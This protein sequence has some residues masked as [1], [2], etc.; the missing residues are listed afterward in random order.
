[1]TT[2]SYL[3]GQFTAGFGE[4]AGDR[5]DIM[6]CG[7]MM[8]QG[9]E[10]VTRERTLD[11]SAGVTA[12]VPSS[13]QF[14]SDVR[15]TGT[16]SQGE[17]FDTFSFSVVAGQTYS[18]ALRGA[19][20]G[21]NSLADPLLFVF[22]TTGAV[23]EFDDDGGV[24][25]TS[26]LTFTAVATGTYTLTSEP[27]DEGDVGDYTVD[28][29]QQRATDRVPATFEGAVTIG[30]GTTFGHV[31]TGGDVDRYK[32]FLEAGKLY[33]FQMAGGTDANDTKAAVTPGELDT[34]L[35]IYRPDGTFIGRSD[36]LGASDLSSGF[37]YTAPTTGFY[38]LDASAAGA[39]QTGG[40]TLDVTAIDP[41]Q[42]DPLDSI[43]WRN[44]TTIPTTTVNGR[45]TAYVYFG[46][47]DENFG[48]TADDGTS[49]MVTIDW[50]PF[51]KQQVM[52]ALDEFER[53]LG[54]DYQVTEDSSQATFRLLKTV[55]T[56]YGA[57][58]FPQDPVFGGDQGVGV[59]NVASG[60]W[61]FQQQQSLERGGFSYAVILHE[62]GHAHGLAHPHDRGGGSEI[63]LGVAGSSGP[64][65]Y[66]LFDLNQGVYSVMSY[67]DANPRGANGPSPFTGATID[68]GWSG[69]LGAFDI[70]VLQ[71]K[72]GVVDRETGNNVYELR[73]ANARGTFYSTIWD[74]AG[75]DEI[76]Y[77]GAR[78]SQIDL[79][80]ATLDYTATGGGVVSFV[81]GI[82]GG[83]TIANDVV[84]EN[85]T[86]G[87]G[88][89]VL[90]G[91]AAGNVLTGNA[92]DDVLHGRVGA[93]T[94][95]GGDGADVLVGGAGDDRLQGGFGVDRFV[96]EA[97]GGIDTIVDFRRGDKIDLTAFVGVD[98][99][100]VTLSNGRI[101][102]ENGANDITI[103][104]QGDRVSDSAFLF[105]T[106][107]S[108]TST[109]TGDTV[110]GSFSGSPSG[111]LVGQF[112]D[113]ILF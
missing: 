5:I 61:R 24:S 79:T 101:F 53:I 108:P 95:I 96:F 68:R 85:A 37:S 75:T 89:D 84:I 25:T 103:L 82:F 60:G 64:G 76:R 113:Y 36:D 39:T 51:E 67:N 59:F 27:F 94:L 97:N 18:V 98:R 41:T 50:N 26:L 92:G 22:D 66:G 73:D 38:Y 72:Y 42:F 69:T 71:D 52:L 28:I 57:Y 6:P 14:P 1:M 4:A 99:S 34:V 45:E 55:S 29:W 78:A 32:V 107:G 88:A 93:D 23:A 48:Q 56:Q 43:N 11:V 58:F 86:G 35:G 110:V 10:L 77:N 62:F 16:I 91:N 15:F 21:P 19:G 80:A 49:P 54:I 87:S 44:S 2:D 65:T 63:M 106:I 9:K 13:I 81:G 90:L 74:M 83:Y 105:A 8:C 33:T 30:T 31:E 109:T 47:S 40:Y 3:V 100:D 7:C 104:V 70:A 17:A 20:T 102:I 111:V 46:D 12:T 112:N